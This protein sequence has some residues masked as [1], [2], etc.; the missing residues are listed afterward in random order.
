MGAAAPLP[1]RN[2][3]LMHWSATARTQVTHLSHLSWSSQPRL[4]CSS[5]TKNYL[6]QLL[7]KVIPDLRLCRR[8][9]LYTGLRSVP[10]RTEHHLVTVAR[11]ETSNVCDGG[12][13]LQQ[14]GSADVEWQQDR[15]SRSFKQ[16]DTCSRYSEC[17]FYPICGGPAKPHDGESTPKIDT[18]LSRPVQSSIPR[19][20]LEC[21]N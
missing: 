18:A 6:Q 21:V 11:H 5:F 20:I 14:R 8:N 1:S 15:D 2:S 10:S 7:Q 17:I 16:Y 9:H 19:R 13:T 4:S 3:D 12:A